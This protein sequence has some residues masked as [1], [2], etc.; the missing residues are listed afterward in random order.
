MHL[1]YPVDTLTI[2]F[3]CR[4]T[5]K[6]CTIFHSTVA[7]FPG[8][9]A[10]KG[11]I[12]THYRLMKIHLPYFYNTQP[13]STL[14]CAIPYVHTLCTSLS[15]NYSFGGICQA[16]QGGSTLCDG[17]VGENI[18]VHISR[19]VQTQ[20]VLTST[21][22]NVISA[23]AFDTVSSHCQ[24]LIRSVLCLHY[25][26]PCGFDA[27]LVSI[28]PEECFYVQKSCAQIWN[29]LQ[30]L[31]RISGTDL[32]FINC[33]NPGQILDPL[34]HCCVDAGITIDT[35]NSGPAQYSLCSG[36]ISLLQNC[37]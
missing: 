25:Y 5:I 21:L 7:C 13:Y 34:P 12:F 1:Y 6:Y 11:S 20:A 29:Q 22:N 16:Y 14:T 37:M 23:S 10:L 31:L 2:V 19:N 24:D 15:F 3:S 4:T 28:C 32:R 9:S 36:R 27:A 33:S 17:E 8:Q 30:R 35:S 18:N 26:T